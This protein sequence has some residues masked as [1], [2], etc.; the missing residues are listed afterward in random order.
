MSFLIFSTF[1]K[2]LA[3]EQRNLLLELALATA[4]A[5][6]GM[7]S[8]FSCCEAVREWL[9]DNNFKGQDDGSMYAQMM[10]K[11]KEV[12]KSKVGYHKVVFLVPI[13]SL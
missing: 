5:N 12:E 3:E 9:L 4:E 7:P 10:R 6:M 13:S 8:I 2:G 1:L 11:A